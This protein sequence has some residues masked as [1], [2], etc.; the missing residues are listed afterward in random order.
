MDGTALWELWLQKL[1]AHFLLLRCLIRPRYDDEKIM[2]LV[3]DVV[4]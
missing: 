4:V 3:I 2:M 1:T